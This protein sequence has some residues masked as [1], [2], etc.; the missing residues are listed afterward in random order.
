M[1]D[2]NLKEMSIEDYIEHQIGFVISDEAKIIA[3]KID[4]G[5]NIIRIYDQ[6]ILFNKSRRKLLLDQ[7]K[8]LGYICCYQQRF[9]EHTKRS[10]C[11]I[12]KIKTYHTLPDPE[13]YIHFMSKVPEKSN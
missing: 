3:G 5:N 6:Q 8:E 10:C 7:L 13:W 9:P 12:F 1:E 4:R 2:F 11:W